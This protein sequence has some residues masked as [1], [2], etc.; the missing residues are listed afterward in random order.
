[1]RELLML[2]VMMT[3]MMNEMMTTI[4]MMI[5]RIRRISLWMELRESLS[6]RAVT[7]SDMGVLFLIYRCSCLMGALLVSCFVHMTY[8]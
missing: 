6:L 8:T 1:M 5:M 7:L 3:R 4:M 2:L